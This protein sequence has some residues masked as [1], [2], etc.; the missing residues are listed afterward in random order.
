[1]AF[2]HWL[3]EEAGGFTEFSETRG[4]WR[5]PSGAIVEERHSAYLVTIPSSADRA[6]WIAALRDRIEQQFEQ[7]EA[8]VEQW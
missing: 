3:I 2:E 5:S 4:A 1:M 8:Y 6:V 7:E